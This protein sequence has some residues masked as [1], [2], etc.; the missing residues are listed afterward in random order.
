MKVFS[1]EL[2]AMFLEAALKAFPEL[3][4]SELTPLVTV[5]EPRDS[6]HGEMACA[7]PLRLAKKLKLGPEKCAQKIIK[8][9][10]HDYRINALE[11]A[12]P[13]YLN[14]KFSEEF[15]REGLKSLSGGF[16]IEGENADTRPIVIDYSST[17][18]AKHMGAH[19]I[20][21]TIIGD[22]LANLFDFFGCETVRINHLGDWGT[23]FGKIIYALREWGDM[24][25]VEKHPNDEFTRLYVKFCN[26]EEKK[27]E[28]TEEAR[29]IF[30]S[31]EDGHEETL[32]L[33]KWITEESLKDLNKIFKRLGVEFD[34]ITGE[35]FYLKMAEEVVKDGLKRKILK[36][37]EGGAIIFPMKGD[38]T[39]AL[40]K[41][42]DGATL[43]LTRDVATIKYRVETWHPAAILYVVDRAQALHFMQNFAVARA[44]G[45][46][47]EDTALEH[48]AFGRMNFADSA[49]STRKGNV[50]KLNDMLDEA[51]TRAGSMAA[52]KG[53]E[54]PREEL[55]KMAEIIGVAS[56]K[57]AVLSQDR[58]K[59]IIFDWDKIITL[60]GNSAPYLLYSYARAKSIMNKALGAGKSAGDPASGM[61]SGMPEFS[62]E[63]ERAMVRKMLKFPEAMHKALIERKPHIIATALYE[64]CQEFNRF[65]GVVPVLTAG[66]ESAKRTRLGILQAFMHQIKSG[67]NIL[68]IPVLERM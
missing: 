23:Q 62:E 68:G 66:D 3:S 45:Y 64:L 14:V 57:Y 20:L 19:H 11:F 9:F 28:L 58:N 41:K 59:D 33:W 21:T 54:L 1:T 40:L 49:M 8:S 42:S 15:L 55:Y 46:A 32:A 24:K 60:E 5:E 38:E 34:Y 16:S 39:P 26:E 37:G 29:K 35:S 47:P 2:K 52:G 67:L 27:P 44:L 30:K 53:T 10:P 25:E 63:A 36:K 48:T 7:A 22:S 51:A 43:Y 13:G 31:M 65:Y 4:E 56:I 61:M 18:A 12:A 50:I 17:N 6:H